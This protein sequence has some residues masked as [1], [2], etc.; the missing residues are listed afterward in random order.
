MIVKTEADIA[1]LLQFINDNEVLA[2]DTETTGLNVR[3]D[4]IIG[5]GISNSSTS[6]Y[7]P[8]Y[9]YS[10]G[11]GLRP[12]SVRFLPILLALKAKKIL[13]FNASFDSRITKSNL[14]VDLLPALHTDVLLLKHTCD[15]NFP[16]GLKE[17]AT[18]LWGHDV[19]KEKEEMLASIKANGGTAKEYYKADTELLARYCEQDCLLTFKLYNHY[20]RQLR[21]E[22]LEQFYYEDEVMPLYKTVTIPMEEAG[23]AIDLPKLNEALINIDADITLIEQGIQF[24]IQPHLS[25]F[26]TW[27]L[28]KDYPLQTFTGK[29][30]AWAKKHNNQYSAWRADNDGHMF[31]LQSK[32]H[33]KKL[34]FDTFQ[35]EP[36]SKTPTGLPQVDEDF[37]QHI[38]PKHDWVAQLIEFNKLNKIK[39]TYLE[40]F[41]DEVEDGIFYPSFMQHRT[42][43]GRYASDLQQLPRPI[44]GDDRIS[45]YT[46][47]IRELIIPIKGNSLLSADYEQLEPRVFAHTSGD[48]ALAKIFTDE[49]D[50]YSE[51]AK[52]TE[53]LTEV[54][55][56]Q[57]QKAKSYAL[58]IAY[59]MTG[60]KLKF[61]LNCTDEQA[62]ALVEKYLTAF[63]GLRRWMNESKEK[64]ISTGA[65]KTETGRMRRLPRAK[66]IYSKYGPD[67]TDSLRLWKTFNNTPDIY[68]NVRQDYKTFKNECNNA[69]NFQVQGLAASIVNRAAIAINKKLKSEQLNA[70]LVMQVHDELVYDVPEAEL[71]HVSAIIKHAM[72][73]TTQLSVPL[74]TTPQSGTNFR[75]CK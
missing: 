19:K 70:R 40:R 15:E 24:A 18:M 54:N 73:N 26:T 12:V 11:Q 59:G 55:K 41:R 29:Q 67:I 52:S 69:I 13:M 21:E 4:T 72:E 37:L 39:S 58:G 31:N 47:I 27:F 62:D 2:Y 1:Q 49:Q 75:Q 45:H 64:A 3:R 35:E 60:Y 30:P 33:L 22:G 68:Q 56:E 6:Y 50:F 43:S 71:E 14:G 34:F 17:I 16:F 28:N 57:R 8:L 74:T 53:G 44:S 66:A 10:N 51:I 32:H 7:V 63:P 38:A 5:F 65:I 61:E 46:S 20:S 42:V 23:V 36:L 9:S 48:S 25:I